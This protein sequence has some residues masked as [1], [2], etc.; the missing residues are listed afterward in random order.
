MNVPKEFQGKKRSAGTIYFQM[1]F[2]PNGAPLPNENNGPI[3][4]TPDDYL[5]QF[6]V[7]GNLQIKIP[8][9]YNL[10]ASDSGL[11]GNKSDPFVKFTPAGSKKEYKYYYF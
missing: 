4:Q 3:K 6:R 10:I 5:K 9:A 1:L 8:F 2:V 7:E 11:M